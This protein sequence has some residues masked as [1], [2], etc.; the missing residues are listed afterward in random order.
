MSN[1]SNV[2]PNLLF[3][4]YIYISAPLCTCQ[5]TD[6]PVIGDPFILDVL[7]TKSYSLSFSFLVYLGKYLSDSYVQKI[8]IGMINVGFSYLCMYVCFL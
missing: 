5:V 4:Y 3:F 1:Y 2:H 6:P 7:Y 8:A